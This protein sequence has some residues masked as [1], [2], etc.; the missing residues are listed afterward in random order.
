MAGRCGPRSRALDCIA[1]NLNW[2]MKGE[3]E[4]ISKNLFSFDWDVTVE[5]F[6][7]RTRR[8]TKDFNQYR[9]WIDKRSNRIPSNYNS[10]CM[11][12]KCSFFPV[13]ISYAYNSHEPPLNT[14]GPIDKNDIFR[15]ELKLNFCLLIQ[16]HQTVARTSS[17]WTL[18]CLPSLSHDHKY[19]FYA[20]TEFYIV[21]SY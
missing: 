1:S 3:F 5:A 14:K 12:I 8:T 16:W 10:V 11:H 6:V 17:K 18:T 2:L 7:G 15:G 4:R 21:S 19:V 9:L 20:W 13:R